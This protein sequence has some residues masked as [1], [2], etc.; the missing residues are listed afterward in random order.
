[1]SRRNPSASPSHRSL[2]KGTAQCTGVETSMQARSRPSPALAGNLLQHRQH[3]SRRGPKSARRERQI[4]VGVFDT[5]GNAWG[6]WKTA[7]GRSRL[8][9]RP[10]KSRILRCPCVTGNEPSCTT[11]RLPKM[12]TM[13][14]TGAPRRGTPAEFQLSA[15]REYLQESCPGVERSA[16]SQ[17]AAWDYISGDDLSPTPSWP[18]NCL[19]LLAQSLRGSCMFDRRP[20]GGSWDVKWLSV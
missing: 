14:P 11:H 17:R 1:M 12:T 5:D 13:A 4:S 19:P 20:E 6:I 3:C 7:T 9:G 15:R 18:F 10:A 8:G 2:A 16:T